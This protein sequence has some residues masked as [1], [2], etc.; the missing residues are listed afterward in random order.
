[1]GPHFHHLVPSPSYELP[2]EINSQQELG[3][4][5]VFSGIVHSASVQQHTVSDNVSYHSHQQQPHDHCGNHSAR[6]Q[7]LMQLPPN[8]WDSVNSNQSDSNS[9]GEG[10][11]ILQDQQLQNSSSHRLPDPNSNLVMPVPSVQEPP[12]QCPMIPSLTPWSGVYDFKVSLTTDNRDKS[13]WCYNLGLQKL[14][15]RP[16]IAV[17]V[18]ISVHGRCDAAIRITPVFKQSQHRSEPVGR[19]YNCK[20]T[21]GCDPSLRE[22]IVQVEGESSQYNIVQGRLIVTVPLG[23]PPPGEDKSTILIKLMC[24]TSCVGGPNRRP[25]CLVFTLLCNST[26]S[27]IGRQILDIKCCKCPNRDMTSERNVNRND[28]IMSSQMS[29]DE[30][31]SSKI[32]EIASEIRVG[33]KRKRSAVDVEFVTKLEPGTTQ[34]EFVAVPVQFVHEVKR[35]INLLMVREAMRQS[36]PNYV[37]YPEE[38]KT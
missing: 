37:L 9:R 20:S 1:M 10:V 6:V 18:N 26:G 7:D 33:Q 5:S 19:C 21:G 25:F 32:R 16:N 11:S 12:Q 17:P 15:T 34:L 13:N 23:R 30:E 35:H 4:I 3:E 38:E 29:V 14:Y 22:H 8:P 27:E 24:L 28:N 36:Q 2:Q 31:K